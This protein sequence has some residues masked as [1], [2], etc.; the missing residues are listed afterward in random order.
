MDDDD[1]LWTPKRWFEADAND[2]E[3]DEDDDGLLGTLGIYDRPIR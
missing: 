1:S 3:D 2:D